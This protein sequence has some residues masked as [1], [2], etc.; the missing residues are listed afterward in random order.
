MY[1]ARY[2]K[3]KVKGIIIRRAWG[4]CVRWPRS[5][6]IHYASRRFYWASLAFLL[7]A[8]TLLSMLFFILHFFCVSFSIPFLHFPCAGMKGT[9]IV[10]GLHGFLQ[11]IQV[12]FYQTWYKINL[13]YIGIQ[14]IN[15]LESHEVWARMSSM[16]LK[17]ILT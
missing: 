2:F 9:A 8:T 15:R 3:L 11:V 7:C 6:H 4:Q 14:Y 12:Y 13:V 5:V 1:I 10:H 16:G 17:G